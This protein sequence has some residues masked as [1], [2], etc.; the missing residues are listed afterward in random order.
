MLVFVVADEDK[1]NKHK[2]AMRSERSFILWNSLDESSG[3]HLSARSARF[4]THLVGPRGTMS[5][6][7]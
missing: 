7:Q 6:S 3:L 1:A 4:Q 5:E 2:A